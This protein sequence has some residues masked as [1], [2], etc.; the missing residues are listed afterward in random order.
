MAEDSFSMFAGQ[1]DEAAASA[2]TAREAVAAASLARPSG[3][4]PELGELGA[5]AIERY[6][7]AAAA[8]VEEVGQELLAVAESF[9]QECRVLAQGMRDAARIE[10]E[11]TRSFTG[12]L[13]AAALE[14]RAIRE[15]FAA[16]EM[17][18]PAERASSEA[19]E[20]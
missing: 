16:G 13:R 19:A 7:E 18:A 6:C 9:H 12:R 11:R 2:R 15:R 8:H 17:P 3:G 14:F 5:E 20:Q 10:A 4:P 1:V